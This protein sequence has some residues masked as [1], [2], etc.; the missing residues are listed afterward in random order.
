[1]L[2]KNIFCAYVIFLRKFKRQRLGQTP[3]K[4]LRPCLRCL[5]SPWL[6]FRSACVEV[7]L[8]QFSFEF[9]CVIIS[10]IKFSHQCLE[11]VVCFTSYSSKIML[12]NNYTYFFALETFVLLLMA[13]IILTKLWKQNVELY[14]NTF[15]TL[16][17]SHKKKYLDRKIQWSRNY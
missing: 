5:V 2:Y 12:Y 10:R 16:L 1:M 7:Y 3:Y 6:I 11:H 13:K 17:A 14:Q 9:Y 4:N 8:K 15:C